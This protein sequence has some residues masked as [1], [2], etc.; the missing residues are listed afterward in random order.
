[1]EV[2]YTTTGIQKSVRSPKTT[3]EKAEKPVPRALNTL[4]LHPNAGF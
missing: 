4:G 3:E 1:M 2:I